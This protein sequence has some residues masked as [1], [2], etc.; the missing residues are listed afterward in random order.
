MII[1]WY[2][3]G[4]LYGGA[5]LCALVSLRELLSRSGFLTPLYETIA[6]F[7]SSFYTA[8]SVGLSAIAFAGSWLRRIGGTVVNIA[9]FH[10]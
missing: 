9:A 7:V 6:I 2:R 4:C 10:S 3:D 5:S 8:F 1:P